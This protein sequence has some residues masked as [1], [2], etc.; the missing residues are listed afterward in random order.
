MSL[1]VTLKI[2]IRDIKIIFPSLQ[3]I[4]FVTIFYSIVHDVEEKNKN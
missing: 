1:V 3:S 2:E 4:V